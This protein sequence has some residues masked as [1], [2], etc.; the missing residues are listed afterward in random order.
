MY[1]VYI[2]KS[3]STGRYYTGSTANLE[4]RLKRHQE[5]R[6]KAT[7]GK[8]PWELIHT[9]AFATRSEAVI[10]E[11]TIKKRGAGRFLNDLNYSG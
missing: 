10:L 7:K 9:K 2:L 4:D 6:S 8:G 3:T 11:F 5:N 1:H